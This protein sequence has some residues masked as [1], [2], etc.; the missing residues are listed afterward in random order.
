[1]GVMWRFCL[2][3]IRECRDHKILGGSWDLVT[4]YNWAYNLN[5]NPP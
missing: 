5:Y 2:G 1:M 3:G 4:T